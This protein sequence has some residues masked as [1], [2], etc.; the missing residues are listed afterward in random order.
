LA[1]D[2]VP[3]NNPSRRESLRVVSIAS[4]PLKR[5]TAA[6]SCYKKIYF[7]MQIVPDFRAGLPIMDL[8][9]VGI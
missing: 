2:E 9:I 1:P 3:T 4:S 6:D 7:T 5:A 8:R